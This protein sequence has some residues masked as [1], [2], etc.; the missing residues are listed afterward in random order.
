MVY[1]VRPMTCRL[2]GIPLIDVS[3]EEFF[4]EWCTRNF[5]DGDPR[6][7]TELR[8][9]FNELF[10]RELLLFQKLIHH[11]TG[12][13]RNEVDLFIPAAVILDCTRIVEAIRQFDR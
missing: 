9:E 2:N 11:L 5:T 6:R 3:G 8:F 10:S 12:T 13:I 4:D 7:I 1:D